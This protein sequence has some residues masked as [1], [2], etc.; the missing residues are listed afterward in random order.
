MESSDLKALENDV[1][2][3]Y[4]RDGMV[5]TLLGL[6]LVMGGLVLISRSMGGSKNILGGLI[7]IFIL[8]MLLLSKAWKR[9]ITYPRLGYAELIAR[10]AKDRH[11]RLRV[12]VPGL[13]AALVAGIILFAWT[14]DKAGEAGLLRH[15]AGT[16]FF[17]GAVALTIAAA[18][19]A[20][21]M[22][23]L[24]LLAVLCYLLCIATYLADVSGGYALEV[25]GGLLLIVGIVRLVLFLHGN[26]ILQGEADGK[27]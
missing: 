8:L 26:P 9:R 18:G 22:R 19:I 10:Q 15:H 3:R 25:T 2:R 13:L 16:L 14:S 4:E 27:G 24:V 20:R 17:G 5:E 23:H 6:G 21:K 12:V 7:P 11:R 1:L